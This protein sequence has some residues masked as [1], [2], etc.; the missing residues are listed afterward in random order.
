MPI[1]CAPANLKWYMRGCLASLAGP[2]SRHH[3]RKSLHGARCDATRLFP[4][5]SSST[6]ALRW[7]AWC[8]F[9]CSSI[10]RSSQARRFAKLTTLA[11]RCRRNESD[12]ERSPILVETNSLSAS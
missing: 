11:R 8:R 3:L 10:L 12:P 6:H 5:R 4:Y 9:T 1:A 2:A 7:F